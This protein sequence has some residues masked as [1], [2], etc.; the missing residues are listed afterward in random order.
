LV[1]GLEAAGRLIHGA[2]R[3]E[4]KGSARE[5]GSPLATMPSYPDLPMEEVYPRIESSD[6]PAV[7]AREFGQGRVVYFPW[8]IDRTFWEVLH[9]DHGRLIAN[10]VRW[11]LREEPPLTVTG[12]GVFDVAVWEQ[13]ESCT[14]HLVNLTNPMMMKGPYRETIPVGPL[15]VRLRLPEGR[16]AK[17][18]RL[19]VAGNK[20]AWKAEGAW[21][22]LTLPRIGLHE[23]VAVDLAGA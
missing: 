11:S 9:P 13:K 8:D 12:A 16:R 5:L 19:L 1:S 14:A 7:V 17:G 3:V 10:A 22:T 4:V 15:G 20:A 21:V 6:I 23:V 18:V 2:Q